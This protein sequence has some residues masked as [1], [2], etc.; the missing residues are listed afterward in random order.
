MGEVFWKILLSFTEKFVMFCFFFAPNFVISHD[1][2]IISLK[3]R[4]HMEELEYGYDSSVCKD[5]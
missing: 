3:I 2:I 1:I 4:T 5:T